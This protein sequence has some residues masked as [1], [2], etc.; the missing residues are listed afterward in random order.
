MPFDPTKPANNSPLDA[1]E[2]R[3]Q[4][5]ALNALAPPVG[6]V[7]AWLKNLPGVP[8]LPNHYVECNGQVLN[9]AESSLHG[10]VIPNLNGASGGAQRFLRGSETSGG[11]GGSDAHSHDV[12]LGYD[13]IQVENGG[14]GFAGTGNPVPTSD[15]G[16]LP[17]FY[18]IV[19]VVRVK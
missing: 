12:T 18:E 1:G 11:T 17:S 7:V 6:A 9:D 13:G 19:W 16:T 8:A 15:A 14:S 3:N 2:M 4:L 10:Q 5:N